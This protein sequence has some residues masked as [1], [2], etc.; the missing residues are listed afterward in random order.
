MKPT[1]L[2]ES[3]KN[4]MKKDSLYDLYRYWVRSKNKSISSRNF[5]WGVA[6]TKNNY[7]EKQD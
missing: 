5:I 2:D 4:I 6:K 1:L 3:Y 7:Q